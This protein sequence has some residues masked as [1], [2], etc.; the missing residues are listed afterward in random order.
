MFYFDASDGTCKSFIYGGC[1]GN[2]NNFLSK[3]AC[4]QTCKGFSS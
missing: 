1:R 2:K 3:H 4:V